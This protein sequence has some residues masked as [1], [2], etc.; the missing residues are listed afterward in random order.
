[1][2]HSD[3]SADGPDARRLFR[4]GRRPQAA[5]RLPYVL[6]IPLKSGALVLATRA[7]WPV[8]GDLYCH[9][10]ESWP[11]DAVVEDSVPVVDVWRQGA[12]VHLILDRRQRRRS[13]FVWAHKD[14]R[15]L[16]F[17]RTQ[18][19]MTQAR[20]GIRIPAA[21]SLKRVLVVDVD[22][23]ERYPW[24][25]SG[26]QVTRRRR[27]LPC[28]DY[29]VRM[30]DRYVAVV[31]RKTVENL[32]QGLNDGTLRLAL[33]ELSGWPRAALFVE[34]RVSDLAK[35]QP[36]R[37]SWLLNL[38]AA[39]Q[40]EFPR[41]AWHFL[42]NRHWAED[43]AYRWLAASVQLESR[44]A[45]APSEEAGHTPVVRLDND[46][47]RETALNQARHG[48]V[49]TRAAYGEAFHVAYPTAAQ[50]LDRLVQDGLLAVV[51]GR[52]RRYYPVD[53]GA[54]DPQSPLPG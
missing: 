36:A 29:A 43:M 5:T 25:F 11:Q 42:E 9:R 50:D 1:M 46:A 22:Q 8:G 26:C 33:A 32:I 39:L 30:G 34:G 54:T 18:R 45:P 19:T 40:A 7:P 38:T 24:K 21:R 47:R 53:P 6:E 44:T 4:I 2:P 3:V 49:W 16:I 28:G 13:L 14:S 12:A 51:G 15:E 37:A 10:L 17:W 31:E 20:P 23:R 52:P 27:E 48:V 41:V 35:Q